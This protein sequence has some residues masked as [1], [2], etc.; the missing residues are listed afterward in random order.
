MAETLR[1][2][3]ARAGADASSRHLHDRA[4]RGDTL[5]KAERT[6]LAAW[7]ERQD[8]EEESWL[9]ASAPQAEIALRLLRN[10]VEAASAQM[11]TVTQDIQTLIAENEALRQEIAAL[12]QRLA[13]S[14]VPQTV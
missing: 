6:S 12:T 8:A 14:A 1:R 3:T 4:T 11:L 13:Q 10:E 7:Y 5:T 9:A 2:E